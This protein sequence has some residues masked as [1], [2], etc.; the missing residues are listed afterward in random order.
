LIDKSPMEIMDCPLFRSSS[1][2][3]FHS[4]ISR[5]SL[6]VEEKVKFWFVKDWC[7]SNSSASDEDR[8]LVIS[9]VRLEMITRNVLLDDVW[10]SKLFS[11]DDILAAIKIQDKDEQ[12]RKSTR[13]SRWDQVSTGYRKGQNLATVGN[14]A[15]VVEGR[16]HRGNVKYNLI[17]G[18]IDYMS[19]D[20]TFFNERDEK[21]I[22]IRLDKPSKF[23]H[24]RILPYGNWKYHLTI[25]VSLNSTDWI[26]SVTWKRIKDFE[27]S[28]TPNECQDI[29]FDAEESMYIKI[30]GSNQTMPTYSVHL[31]SCE[32]YLQDIT[33]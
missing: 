10:P 23:N 6:N 28:G 21:G 18:I 3:V 25:D 5:N 11:S 20:F 9:G 29:T 4:I 32:V 12:A 16:V 8:K 24:I 7:E 14:G 31:V 30:A 19:Y 22:V 2:K 26:D 15:S 33:G 13:M 17:S 1:G 27:T